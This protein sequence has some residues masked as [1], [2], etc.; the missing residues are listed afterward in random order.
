MALYIDTS[1]LVKLVLDERESENLRLIV[2]AHELVSSQISITELIRTVARNQ[3]ASVDAA[4]ELLGSVTLV[5]L[6]ENLSARAAWVKPPSL[7]SLDAIH[8]A[9]AAS[10]QPELEALVTY[11]KKM[12]EAAR[13][14]GLPVASPGDTA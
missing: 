9:T 4:R 13:L 8:I 2:G 11:D 5:T 7:R 14:A 10:L 3:P 1:A 6:S 12:G